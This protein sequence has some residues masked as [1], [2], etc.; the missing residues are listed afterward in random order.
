[1]SELKENRYVKVIKD[2]STMGVPKGTLGVITHV[3]EPR[4]LEANKPY[5]CEIMT[6]P[7]LHLAVSLDEI[8]PCTVLGVAYAS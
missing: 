1:M 2:I 4:V 8:E 5:V 7:E 6:I 3:F